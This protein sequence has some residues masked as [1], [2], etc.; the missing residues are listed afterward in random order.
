MHF[1][2]PTNITYDCFEEVMVVRRTSACCIQQIWRQA[3]CTLVLSL[4]PDM[5]WLYSLVDILMVN[6]V[7]SPCLQ[8]VYV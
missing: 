8:Y 5:T 1:V 4:V 7:I 2:R 3:F 6:V